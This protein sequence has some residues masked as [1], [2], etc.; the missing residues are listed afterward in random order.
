MTALLGPYAIAGFSL[1]NPVAVYL[2]DQRFNAGE[3]PPAGPNLSGQSLLA[4]RM[5]NNMAEQFQP[6]STSVQMLVIPISV[7]LDPATLQATFR[8]MMGPVNHSAAVIPLVA[9]THAY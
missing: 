7:H 6:C 1:A 8:I 9:S 4:T 5:I 2:F 3:R